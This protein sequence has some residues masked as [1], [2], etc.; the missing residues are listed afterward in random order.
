[1]SH[2]LV[3]RGNRPAS[4]ARRRD[5]YPGRNRP[6]TSWCGELGP[7]QQEDEMLGRGYIFVEMTIKDP[8]GFKQ[9][10]ALSAPAV[11]AAGGRYIVR[12]V[13]PEMLEGAASADR[14]VVVEFDTVAQAREFYH[15]AAYQAARAKRLTT[16]EFR[17]TLLE[18]AP[19]DTTRA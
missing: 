11:H 1:L 7:L 5:D 3:E 12:G 19:P 15:S 16:A 4:L 9:Y 6:E 8:E 13:A 18:G 10:T 14:T 17:M 2:L